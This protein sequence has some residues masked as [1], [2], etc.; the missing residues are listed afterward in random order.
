MQ[1]YNAEIIGYKRSR[2]CKGHFFPIFEYEDQY[3]NTRQYIR[4]A[5]MERTP[6]S[7]NKTYKISKFGFKTFEIGEINITPKRWF[8]VLRLLLLIAVFLHPAI[9]IVTAIFNVICRICYWAW[10]AK[11]KH[12]A[13]KLKGDYIKTLGTVVDYSDMNQKMPILSNKYVSYLVTEYEYEG[14]KYWHIGSI[15]C[16]GNPDLTNTSCEIYINP[17]THVIMD[18]FEANAPVIMIPQLTAASIQQTSLNV[19]E[20]TKKAKMK[21]RNKNAKKEAPTTECINGIVLKTYEYKRAS[22]W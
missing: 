2:R 1:L 10:K 11:R 13:L 18:E 21:N 12:D 5:S 16:S 20:R 4:S 15:G 22:N 3:G 19:I 14:K 7:T 17:K 8:M 6:F 9:A